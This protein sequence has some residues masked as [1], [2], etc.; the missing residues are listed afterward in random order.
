MDKVINI[1]AWIEKS[2]RMRLKTWAKQEFFP[3]YKPEEYQPEEDYNYPP[4]S[5]SQLIELLE[6]SPDVAKQFIS[7]NQDFFQPEIVTFEDAC[8]DPEDPIM[9]VT[10]V[11]KRYVV[12][13]TMETLVE[14]QEWL[15]NIY[16]HYLANYVPC[17]DENEEFWESVSPGQGQILY[18]STEGE[19]LD[20]IRKHG[21][22]ATSE[23]RSMSNK[24]MSDAVFANW[25]EE[26]THSYGDTVIGIDVGKMKEEGYMPRVSRE[27]PFEDAEM[28]LALAHKIGVQYDPYQ[29]FSSEGLDPETI[30]FY[31]NIPPQYLVFWE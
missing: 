31:G 3:W 7:A 6:E 15:T 9:I 26:A 25:T 11:G 4:P 24:G 29:E 22:E 28:R 20:S 2:C 14:A 17:P 5:A 27:E 19:N 8:V 13:F 23:T 18:H 12:D 16:D 21:L 30:A 10:I 1:R